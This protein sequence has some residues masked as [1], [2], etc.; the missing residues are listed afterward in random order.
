MIHDANSSFFEIPLNSDEKT[1]CSP[2]EKESNWLGIVIN[3][4]LSIDKSKVAF[5]V[6][7]YYR[8]SLTSIINSEPLTIKVRHIETLK[9]PLQLLKPLKKMW[10]ITTIRYW[11]ATSIQIF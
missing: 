6:C 4:P 9:H 8:L 2:A 7:G 11:V 1:A 5:P 3:A 10:V